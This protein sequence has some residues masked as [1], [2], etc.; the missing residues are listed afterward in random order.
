MLR[1]A[2]QAKIHPVLAGVGYERYER[3][4]I[5]VPYWPLTVRYRLRSRQYRFAFIHL[6]NERLETEIV[7]PSGISQVAMVLWRKQD[8]EQHSIQRRLVGRWGA[9]IWTWHSVSHR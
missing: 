6:I 5:H 2:A 4:D 8:E 9:I 1:L 3:F 7:K